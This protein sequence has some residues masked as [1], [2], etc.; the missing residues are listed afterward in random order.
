MFCSRIDSLACASI[1]QKTR[2]LNPQEATLSHL[3][4]EWSKLT[5]DASALADQ[6]LT[7]PIKHAMSI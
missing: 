7:D 4:Q 1:A 3:Q 6:P 5:D 2:Q